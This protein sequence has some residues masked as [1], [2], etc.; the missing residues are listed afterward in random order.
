MNQPLQ[1]AT[2]SEVA[3]SNRQRARCSSGPPAARAP[4]P[5]PALGSIKLGVHMH[6]LRPRQLRRAPLARTAPH[7]SRAHR[8]LHTRACAAGPRAQP[9]RARRAACARGRESA[10][11][12]APPVD[13]DAVLRFMDTTGA[14]PEQARFLLEAAN[15]NSDVAA[16]MYFGGRRGAIRRSE[17]AIIRAQGCALDGAEGRG[18]REAPLWP[19]RAAV[20]AALV[21]AGTPCQLPL[22]QLAFADARRLS[23]L[24]P[25]S[26]SRPPAAPPPRRPPRP[27]ARRPAPARP[28]R[29]GPPRR[30]PEPSTS[31]RRTR[32]GGRRAA[33]SRARCGC[34]WPP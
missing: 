23:P 2:D 6:T 13:D 8:P 17:A 20:A 34:R 28:P 25:Q 11:M 9:A 18:L 21:A 29:R 3:V 12:A 27:R 10:G 5:C 19:R 1:R 22:R 33:R 14:D 30:R 26:T 16:H 15:G 4:T 31:R 32:R 24:T 7:P